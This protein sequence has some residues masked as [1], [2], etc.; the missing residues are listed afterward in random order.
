LIKQTFILFV[1][2][3]LKLLVYLLEIITLYNWD[4]F[5]SFLCPDGRNEGTVNCMPYNIISSQR[6]MHSI[7]QYVSFI[8][9]ILYII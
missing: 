9:Y 3:S 7:D 1:S 2:I 5:Y 8:L 6:K 4:I